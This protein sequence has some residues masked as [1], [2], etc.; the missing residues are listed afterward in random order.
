MTRGK[1]AAAVIALLL[2]AGIAASLLWP[3]RPAAPPPPVDESRVTRG[4]QPSVLVTEPL[5][6]V[7]LEQRGFSLNR[8][9]GAGGKTN[10][11]LMDS[12]A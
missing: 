12:R 7:A 8:A 3:Q 9:L 6:L 2:G 1:I 4:A 5:A 11:D 10:A